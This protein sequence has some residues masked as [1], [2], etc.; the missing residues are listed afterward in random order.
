MNKIKISPITNKALL[1]SAPKFNTYEKPE[2]EKAHK[3]TL[4]V[5]WIRL[6]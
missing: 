6:K 3:C 5:I 4:G 1:L 2:P